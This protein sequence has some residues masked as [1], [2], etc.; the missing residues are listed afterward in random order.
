MRAK[1]RSPRSRHTSQPCHHAPQ[2]ETDWMGRTYVGCPIC[3]RWKLMK[4][5][6]AP[7]DGKRLAA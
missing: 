4:A 7:P 2:Y 5:T 3:N 6:P 1:K